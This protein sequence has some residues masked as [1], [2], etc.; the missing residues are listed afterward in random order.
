MHLC[1]FCGEWGYGARADGEVGGGEG[2]RRSGGLEGLLLGV[3]V[4]WGLGKRL[5]G[6]LVS[7]VG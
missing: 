1:V 4:L 3:G 2:G 7:R 5:K 6:D